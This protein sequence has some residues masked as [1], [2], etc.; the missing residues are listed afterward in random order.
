LS[1]PV[2]RAYRETI[3]SISRDAM[4]AS[5]KPERRQ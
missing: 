3:R 1:M 2:L 5:D 4:V